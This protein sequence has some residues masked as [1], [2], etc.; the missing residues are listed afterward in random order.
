ML[1]SN[2]SQYHQYISISMVS[3]TFFSLYFFLCTRTIDVKKSRYIALESSFTGRNRLNYIFMP[4]YA[5]GSLGKS[6][7]KVIFLVARPLLLEK[8]VALV[9]S[10]IYHCLRPLEW[11]FISST[12]EL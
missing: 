3:N 5:H 4:T 7:M 1:A 10:F 9:Y 2:A 11:L 8:T 12:I 6:Q